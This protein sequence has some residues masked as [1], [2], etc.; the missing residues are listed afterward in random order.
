[1][2]S[3]Q[4]DAGSAAAWSEISI[5]ERILRANPDQQGTRAP[6]EKNHRLTKG[7]VGDLEL[8]YQSEI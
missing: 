6:M 2:D 8:D 7:R 5:G 1:M 3:A 4:P